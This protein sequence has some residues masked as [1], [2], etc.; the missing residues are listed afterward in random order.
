L[1]ILLREQLASP[2]SWDIRILATELNVAS[3]ARAAEASYS[4]WSFR[5][6]PS[7]VRQRYFTSLGSRW[8]LADSIK[9]MVAFE[10]LNLMTTSLPFLGPNGHGLDL[11]VCR[12]VTIYFTAEAT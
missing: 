5:E 1:A 8:V 3:L 12:N 6:T 10:R 9:R 2:E 11:T 7:W 4:E